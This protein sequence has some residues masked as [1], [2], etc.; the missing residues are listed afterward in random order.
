M[1]HTSQIIN[2]VSICNSHSNNRND[3][4]TPISLEPDGNYN[5]NTQEMVNVMRM[6]LLWRNS[7]NK[8]QCGDPPS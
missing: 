1:R 3:I 8:L 4:Y 6:H 7:P 2:Q 5:T